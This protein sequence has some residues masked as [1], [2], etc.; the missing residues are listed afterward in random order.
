[1][2]TD[3]VFDLMFNGSVELLD[4]MG[5]DVFCVGYTFD[6]TTI[7]EANSHGVDAVVGWYYYPVDL[8]AEIAVE[9]F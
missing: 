9:F 6:T 4:G 1:V 5:E 8:H 3:N 7:L 2:E